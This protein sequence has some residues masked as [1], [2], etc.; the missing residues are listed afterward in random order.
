MPVTPQAEYGSI[1]GKPIWSELLGSDLY[2][3][4]NLS[5]AGRSQ[6]EP[7]L[8]RVQ[9]HPGGFQQFIDLSFL[10]DSQKA[11]VGA[12]LALERRWLDAD[13]VA[14]ANGGDL[15][16]SLLQ[17]LGT[18][19]RA[20]PEVARQLEEAVIAAAGTITKGPRDPV[21]ADAQVTPLVDGFLGTRPSSGDEGLFLGQ[22][23]LRVTNVERANGYWFQLD[24]GDCAR[25]PS[26]VSKWSCDV[27]GI[28]LIDQQVG[29]DPL[30]GVT[31]HWVWV[32][33]GHVGHPVTPS[34]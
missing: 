31:L 15:A 33:G 3:W 2:S 11:V 30:S 22:R 18:A 24:W 27:C 26:E 16:K 28:A 29:E 9:L 17:W 6:A 5:E 20:L 21:I 8:V 25:R 23:P 32:P 10:L 14:L 7:G 34:A 12:S 4:F 19:D 13:R 1:A